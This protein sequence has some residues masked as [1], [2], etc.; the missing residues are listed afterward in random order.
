MNIE[1]LTRAELIELHFAIEKKLGWYGVV[2]LCA[3]DVADHIQEQGNSPMPSEAD[4]RAACA[5]VARK[6]EL[7]H[8][9]ILDWAAEE[10]IEYSKEQA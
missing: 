6:A 7:D 1:N 10:A 8:T 5:Y 9:H 3:E 4:I 2:T